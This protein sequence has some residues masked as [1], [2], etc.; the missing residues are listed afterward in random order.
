MIDVMKGELT[1]RVNYEKVT[2]SI[3]DAIKQHDLVKDD[4]FMVTTSEVEHPDK[5]V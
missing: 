5:M 2:F 4:S 3:S 1:L